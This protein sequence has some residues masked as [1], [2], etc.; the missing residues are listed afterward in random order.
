MLRSSVT[1]PAVREEIEEVATGEIAIQYEE[2]ETQ[3]VCVC[4]CVC[5]YTHVNE[6]SNR[7]EER[8]KVKHTTRQS[9]RAYV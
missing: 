3:C 6:R 8:S 7:K 4:V 2:A 9:N 5:M 1:N